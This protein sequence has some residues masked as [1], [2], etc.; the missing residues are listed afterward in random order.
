MELTIYK[1]KHEGGKNFLVYTNDILKGNVT[2]SRKP[3]SSLRRNKSQE[4]KTL[5]IAGVPIRCSL[6]ILKKKMAFQ[7]CASTL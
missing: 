5:S 4:D 3:K 7:W 2:I 1:N 6:N